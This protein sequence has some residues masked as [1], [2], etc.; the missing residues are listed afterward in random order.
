MGI[1]Q[2]SAVPLCVVRPGVLVPSPIV[3]QTGEEAIPSIFLSKEALY[4]VA[5]NL[6]LIFS[7]TTPNSC[8]CVDCFKEGNVRHPVLLLLYRSAS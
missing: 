5:L 2:E 7:Q 8:I 3:A 1:H 4:D 6:C